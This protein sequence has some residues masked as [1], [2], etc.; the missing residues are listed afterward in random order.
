MPV[1]SPQP[2]PGLSAR[3]VALPGSPQALPALLPWSLGV[4]SSG[5]TA[6][7]HPAGALPAGSLSRPGPQR[8]QLHRTENT[9]PRAL[10]WCSR[11][12]PL[13]ARGARVQAPVSPR[14]QPGQQGLWSHAPRPHRL[15]TGLLPAS[16]PES[17]P[18]AVFSDSLPP[19]EVPRRAQTTHP[20]SLTAGSDRG[21]FTVGKLRH[22]KVTSLYKPTWLANA[23]SNCSPVLLPLC[24]SPWKCAPGVPLPDHP[25][26]PG[27]L[28][29]HV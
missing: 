14:A 26:T 16:S 12:A 1:H 27:G 24:H 13:E 25:G 29:S 2:D 4:G 17:P 22:R 28:P 19:P 7:P 5:A 6:A 10:G 8:P 11:Q 21:A 20:N 15:P 9:A 18:E 3:H 23:R